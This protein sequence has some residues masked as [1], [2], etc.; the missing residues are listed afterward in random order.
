[1]SF[2]AELQSEPSP[3]GFYEAA[4]GLLLLRLPL[5]GHLTRKIKVAGN[6]SVLYR[7][8][9]SDRSVGGVQREGQFVSDKAAFADCSRA[10]SRVGRSGHLITLEFELESERELGTASV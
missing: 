10:L 1:M 2:G 8:C 4:A 7:C 3:F 9:E 6:L 5:A